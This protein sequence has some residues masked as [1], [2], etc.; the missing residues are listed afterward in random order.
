M[1]ITQTNLQGCFVIN[2]TVF[3]DKRGYFIETFNQAKFE[4]SLGIKTNFVQDNESQSTFGTI[5]GLHMQV[6][7]KSQA[8]LVRVVKG[9]I[10]DVVIDARPESP[11]YKQSFSIK[12]SE[13]NKTQLYVP[14]GFLHGFSVLSDDAIFSYKCDNLY[15]KTAETGVNPLDSSLAIDWGLKNTEAIIS[16]KDQ[17]AQS[18]D[19]FI[20]TIKK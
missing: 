1:K 13:E 15:D 8:K 7:D 20:S 19:R 18:F 6:G 14:R 3:K 16:E 17:N 12:L 4:E 5:R 9:I 2:P 10:K 11:S